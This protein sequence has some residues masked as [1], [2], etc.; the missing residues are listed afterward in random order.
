MAIVSKPSADEHAPYYSTYIS[1]SGP[2][3][4]VGLETQAAS[5]RQLLAA[6]GE[7]QALH[8]YA[9]G[10][11]SVKE[12]VGHMCDAERIFA[13][14]ALRFARADTTELPGFDENLYVPAG[15]FDTRLLSDL[16]AEFA[17]VRSA[18]VALYRS[19]DE[20][21]LVR[22]GSANGQPMSVRAL[23][24]VLVG[25]EA[26]HVAILLERYGLKG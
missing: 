25:H 16:A 5:T 6:A 22:R 8:R 12:V 11:W 19:M 18:T 23:G 24:H 13:Y 1:L 20:A 17:A 4:L 21:A 7:E 14:R 2:D 26:H 10:K 3:A 9:A 15:R